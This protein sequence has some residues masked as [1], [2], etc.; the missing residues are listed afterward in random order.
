MENLI[1]GI[2]EEL[3][4]NRELLREYQGIGASGFFGSM[5]ITSK[6]NEGEK[7]IASGDIVR[8]L[9]AYADLQTSE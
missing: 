6:I 9:S 1:D 5:V 4:R 2:N 8:M 7:S 3:N